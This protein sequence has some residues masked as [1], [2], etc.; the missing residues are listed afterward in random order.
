MV[1]VHVLGWVFTGLLL[2]LVVVCAL[3]GRGTL[4]LNHLV[5]I[6][7]APLLRDEDAWRRGHAAAVGPSVVAFVVAAICSV[8][9]LFAPAVAGGAIIAFVLGFVWV[10]IVSTRAASR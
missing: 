1:V 2:L 8:T 3:A 9:G 4:R 10:C 6:R 5:G 7:L